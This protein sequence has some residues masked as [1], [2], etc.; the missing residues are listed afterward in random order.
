M[1]GFILRGNDFLTAPNPPAGDSVH[2]EYISQLCV[3]S[4][5][6][7]TTPDQQKFENDADTC[8]FPGQIIEQGLRWRFLRAKGLS[9][10]QEYQSWIEMLQWEASR[11]G[12][13]ATLSMA[14]SYND[15]L[16]GPYVPSFNFP[17]P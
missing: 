8:A 12:G 5:G 9:Y 3:Y 16:A 15:W 17:G 13:M 6:T 14:G 1:F 4:S 10:E 11:T 2:Y 7:A